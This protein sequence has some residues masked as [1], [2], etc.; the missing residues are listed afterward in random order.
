MGKLVIDTLGLSDPVTREY[1][2]TI[3]S[4]KLAE[5]ESRSRNGSLA[6]SG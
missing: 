6:V 1:F 4:S 5:V 2:E 3:L